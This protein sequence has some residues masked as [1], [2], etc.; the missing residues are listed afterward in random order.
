MRLLVIPLTI[1]AF[2]AL[3]ISLPMMPAMAAPTSDVA[4]APPATPVYEVDAGA[5]PGHVLA[6]GYWS[7][8]GKRHVWKASRWISAREGFIWVCDQWSPRGDK[9]HF[10]PGHWEED[11]DYVVVEEPAAEIASDS[12][13][14]ST[15]PSEKDTKKPIKKL[16]KRANYNDTMKWPRVMHH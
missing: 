3:T 16:L 1:L 14:G 13:S 7:W 10:T 15:A 4:T 9:W 2:L 12:A 6:P 5:R 11:E 8:N